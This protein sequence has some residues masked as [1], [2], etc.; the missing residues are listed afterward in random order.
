MSLVSGV[1]GAPVERGELNETSLVLFGEEEKTTVKGSNLVTGPVAKVHLLFSLVERETSEK[2]GETVK[3]KEFWE[4]SVSSYSCEPCV[5][6]LEN[7][8]RLLNLKTEEDP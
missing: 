6:I 3:S 4:G 2:T 1:V 7:L 5:M 8:F